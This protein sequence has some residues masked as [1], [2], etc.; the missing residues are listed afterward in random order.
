M[1]LA[2]VAVSP[3]RVLVPAALDL[4]PPALGGRMHEFSGCTMGTTWNVRL[5][6]SAQLRRTRVQQAIQ[7]AL[8]AVVE[9]MSTWDARSH[10]CRFNRAAPATWQA[11]PDVFLE[12][13]A[14]AREV[15]QRSDGAFDPTAGA[16]VD[17]WGFGP[18]PRP[19]LPEPAALAHA[20][21]TAGWKRLE[22]DLARGAARQPG[23][24]A[25]DLSAIAK[26]YGVDRVARQLHRLGLDSHLVEVGGELRGAG[27]KPDGQPWWVQLEHPAQDDD[28]TPTLL[29]LHGVSVA[30]S[31]DYRRWFDHDGT[32][33]S[34]TIDPRDGLPIRH[35][36]ASVTVIHAECMLADAW[37]TA[38]DVLGPDAGPALAD[39]L[40]LAARFVL[41]RGAGFEELTSAAF[42][43]LLR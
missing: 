19:G 22:L 14:C 8:D 18:T 29:A 21:A 7:G 34:H 4:T 33:Y 42:D 24:L 36:L 30:T 39:R 5:V 31:G 17:A 27:V 37:S 35:G 9:Q 23:G 20:R 40:G 26:G 10:L 12:V 43:R 2:V 15:A 11:L 13:L 38:L 6:A 28:A 3:R 32:R 1:S 16:L 25:L 41:R